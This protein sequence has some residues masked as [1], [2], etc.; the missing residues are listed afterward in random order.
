MAS[1]DLGTSTIDRA[2]NHR[3]KWGSPKKDSISEE[4][5]TRNGPLAN[6]RS[7][8]LVEDEPVM[9]TV[10]MG[11]KGGWTGHQ[12]GYQGRWCRKGQSPAS[13]LG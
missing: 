11:L 4:R 8:R 2:Q 5:R 13:R 9:W 6:T 7:K 12:E 3:N 10:K 1:L